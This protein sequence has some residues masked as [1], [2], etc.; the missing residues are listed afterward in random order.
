MGT[1]IKRFSSWFRIK[2]G[3]DAK[4]HRPPFFKER[5]VWWCSIGENVGVEISGK[6]AYFR[7]PVLV[8]R[9][10]DRY[11]FIG[12]PLTRTLR[13]GDWFETIIIG[14]IANTVVIAQLR[15]FDYR[16]MDKICATIPDQEFERVIY[17]VMRLF[18]H[19][20]SPASA[21]AGGRG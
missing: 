3:I 9:K 12:A 18:S 8:L 13:N 1:F 21:E 5:E 10:L 20:R 2:S 14:G 16:R 4:S 11:T 7:R 15:H 17:A 19:N 6:G